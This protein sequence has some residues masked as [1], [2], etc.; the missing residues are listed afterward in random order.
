MTTLD[1]LHLWQV[2]QDKA[3]RPIPGPYLLRMVSGLGL[4]A[5]DELL[6]WKLWAVCD[7][8]G[9]FI[10][11]PK[12]LAARL[13]AP[14]SRPRAAL[15]R[16][17]TARV[18]ELYEVDGTQ[19]GRVRGY[20]Q[21]VK[22]THAR[23]PIHPA[24][25]EVGEVVE[26]VGGEGTPD[27]HPDRGTPSLPPSPPSLLSPPTPPPII[28]PSPP[29]CPPPS[30]EAR[31]QR[32]RAPGAA[33]EEQAELLVAA[34]KAPA[35]APRAPRLDRPIATS[36]T[37]PRPKP[38]DRSEPMPNLPP[39]V[40]PLPAALEQLAQSWLALYARVKPELKPS[41]QRIPEQLLRDAL[42]RLD[43]Q[44]GTQALRDACKRLATETA[45]EGSKWWGDPLGN[46]ERKVQWAWRDLPDRVRD[47]TAAGRAELGV[48]AEAPK[49]VEDPPKATEDP[50]KAPA[51]TTRPEPPDPSDELAE[52]WA[53]AL[54]RLR[55]EVEP[56]DMRH[57]IQP[58]VAQGLRGEVAVL[59]VP[60]ESHAAW[61]VESFGAR[62]EEAMRRAGGGHWSL[63]YEPY[64]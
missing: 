52:V 25:I 14:T 8:E 60:D 10:A 13:N 54:E 7:D 59:G 6:F 26:G 9:A 58:I 40:G 38:G 32:A 27:G 41:A 39:P 22:L 18:I 33:R 63:S 34:K 45:M 24:P 37:G 46:L 61:V 3:W 56:W 17:A 2:D 48:D 1:P 50:P 15:E 5:A 36:A 49:A 31:A 4:R 44:Y 19:Y 35:R 30:P 53:A 16:L 11:V 28:P 57:W 12:M 64:A 29:S 47:R 23:S 42:R 51:A 43:E 21:L 20:A 55:A 62:L